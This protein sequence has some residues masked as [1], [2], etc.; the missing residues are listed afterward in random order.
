MLKRSVYIFVGCACIYSYRV[1]SQT[2][3]PTSDFPGTERDDA[4]G[5]VINTKAYCGTG[6]Q[7]WFVA[8]SDFNALDMPADSWTPTTALP[9]GNER[10]YATGFSDGNSGFIALGQNG[11]TWF[12]DVWMYSPASN[13]WTARTALPSAGRMGAACF[14]IGT[15]S[16]IIGGRTS[17]S[18]SIN[19]VW[20]YDMTNDSW[21]RK[22]DLPFGSRWRASGASLNNKGYLIFGK[23]ENNRFC[24]EIFEYDPALDSW[25]QIGVFP[26]NGRVYSSMTSVSGNLYVLAG[27]DS[28]GASYRD[29]WKI[30]PD[31]LN[32]QQLQSIPSS[33]RRGGIAFTYSGTLY[34][35][36][37]IDSMN[38]RLKETWKISLPTSVNEITAD[39]MIHIYPNPASDF[40]ILS[41]EN[42]PMFNSK[43]I[44][45]DLKGKEILNF[46]SRE[47]RIIMN[48]SGFEEGIYIL[49]LTSASGCYH[50]KLIILH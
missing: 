30:N 50:T 15:I 2:W 26:G 17:S 5:F 46:Q 49:N 23:D 11:S 35:T 19:E 38:T 20:A 22:N 24:K 37:G 32:W 36:T 4:T 9:A 44:I 45:T 34:Y 39:K 47:S 29:L 13:A 14:V 16:Y 28:L 7:P 8:S 31:T 21:T 43:I 18:I 3:V 33:G 25:T 42:I 1:F 40:L 48:T 6:L 10:Q 41:S 12:N 27:L